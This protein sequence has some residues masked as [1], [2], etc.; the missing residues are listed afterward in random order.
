MGDFLGLERHG[1]AGPG[2]LER[3]AEER[4]RGERSARRRIVG[5]GHSTNV[6]GRS[7]PSPLAGV[8]ASRDRVFRGTRPTYVRID[9]PADPPEV[10]WTAPIQRRFRSRDSEGMTTP[11]QSSSAGSNPDAPDHDAP[12]DAPDHPMDDPADDAIEDELD[13]S[14]GRPRVVTAEISRDR[15]WNSVVE[16]VLERGG[17]TASARRN[18]VGEEAVLFRCAAETT[19]A[20]L[21]DLLGSPERFALVG[22]KRIHA[23]D[24]AVVLACVRTL[25]GRPRKLIGCVP[26]GDDAILAVARAILHATNRILEAIP[27]ASDEEWP[28]AG[29]SGSAPAAADDDG[30]D[31]DDDGDDEDARMDDDV[32]ED[33]R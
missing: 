32:D 19:L 8:R 27:N 15:G 17:R 13:R 7:H 33:E 16:V 28:E 26:V 22:A 9:G 2:T 6:A 10:P 29:E 20:A 23:F 11:E 3:A 5:M 25:T 21:D 14:L 30:G 31:A 24:S 18:A 4:R 12:P 1:V